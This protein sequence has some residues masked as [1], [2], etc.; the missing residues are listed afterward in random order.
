[1][2]RTA[3][4]ALFVSL[5]LAAGCSAPE[6]E[7]HSKLSMTADVVVTSDPGHGLGGAELLASEQHV[8]TTSEDGHA[9]VALEGVE[10]DT[11]T[12]TV[13]CPDGFEPPAPVRV[14]L[15]RL[16]KDSRPPR[17]DARCAPIERTFV[18]G[19]RTDNGPDLPI[20]RLGK[21]VGRTDASGAAH[22]VV[23]AKVNEQV[24]ITLDT[25][26][27][28]RLPALRPESPTLTFVA[29]DHD[30]FVVLEQRFQVERAGAIRQA[31]PGPAA[32]PAPKRI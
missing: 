22:V 32:L 1:M 28:E 15:R 9:S 27:A 16:S 11:V 5:M 23:R 10:G 4:F 19:I 25:K 14:A 2:K 6:T 31:T 20:Y 24:S 26:R 3:P 21:L 12:L 29:G 17:F 7:D 13:R 30:E 18:V 8:A